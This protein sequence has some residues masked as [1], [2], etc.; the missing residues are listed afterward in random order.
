[1]KLT[2][3]AKRDILNFWLQQIAST[4]DREYQKRVWIRGEGPEFDDFDETVCHF[5]QEG[6]AIL[7]N[8]KDF[9]ISRN[10]YHLLKKFRNEFDSFVTG[11]MS[12]YPPEKFIDT[13]EWEKIMGMAKEVLKVFNYD[14]ESKHN[15]KKRR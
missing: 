12:E 15:S 7:E 13:P 3:E 5:F 8:Y 2:K 4:A 10:Q 1:M 11:S 9:G 14:K 6:D